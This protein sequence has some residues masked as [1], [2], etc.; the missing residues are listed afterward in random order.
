MEHSRWRINYKNLKGFPITTNTVL[1]G[2]GNNKVRWLL[3]KIILD[4]CGYF[5]GLLTVHL[6]IILDI[7]QLD[8]HLLYFTI[9]LLFLYMFR[10]LYAHH[11]EVELY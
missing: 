7:D 3:L 6:S 2:G 4:P 8:A 11:Q 10:A 9:R 1:L 5:C